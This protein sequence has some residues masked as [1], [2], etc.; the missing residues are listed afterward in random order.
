MYQKNASY[1]NEGERR[2]KNMKKILSLLLS[3]LLFGTVPLFAMENEEEKGHTLSRQDIISVLEEGNAHIMEDSY[4]GV[5]DFTLPTEEVI[6]VACCINEKNG[7]IQ[8]NVVVL[9]DEKDKPIDLNKAIAVNTRGSSS[10]YLS[11]VTVTVNY[12]SAVSNPGGKGIYRPY[13][14][15]FISSSSKNVKVKYTTYGVKY[16]LDGTNAGVVADHIINCS[17]YPATANQYYE[18]TY[19]YSGYAGPGSNK[20]HFSLSHYVTLYINGSDAGS[21]DCPGHG[22]YA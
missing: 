21:F 1:Y 20:W 6:N 8:Q 3:V 10:H 4:I 12:Y 16:N 2:Y 19:Y 9:L 22:S 11:G 17:A 18:T 14:A 15:S 7:E 13:K 5:V